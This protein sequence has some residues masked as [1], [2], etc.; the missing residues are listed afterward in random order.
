MDKRLEINI[1]IEVVESEN[2]LDDAWQLLIQKAKEA[3]YSAYAPYSD[4]NVGAAVQLDNDIIVTGNNQENAVYPTGLCAERVALF[5]AS[6]QYPKNAV[7]R[8]AIMAQKGKKGKF[9]PATPCGGCRQAISEYETKGK[10]PIRV[11]MMGP[12]HTLYLVN[13]SDSLLPL[14][15]SPDSLT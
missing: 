3:S 10:I 8:M 12:H 15:F 13:N 9:L 5:A 2:D 11:L 6:S 1:K 14:K 4:F 7:K